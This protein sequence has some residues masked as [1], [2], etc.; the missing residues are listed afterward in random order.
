M[1]SSLTANGQYIFALNGAR[2]F[3]LSVTNVG[4]GSI[5]ILCSPRYSGGLPFSFDPAG[6]VNVN[7][8]GSNG[9]VAVI[10]PPPPVPAATSNP[11]NGVNTQPYCPTVTSPVTANGG[12]AYSTRCDTSGNQFV[13]QA[14]PAPSSAQILV[15]DSAGPAMFGNGN[16]NTTAPTADSYAAFYCPGACGQVDLRISGLT[17]GNLYY[18][19]SVDSTNGSN[20][21]WVS[22]FG[23]QLGLQSP[24]SNTP[25]YFASANGV[26]QLNVT[27]AGWIRVRAAG[28]LS[29]TPT[30]AWSISPLSGYGNG[31]AWTAIKNTPTVTGLADSKGTMGAPDVAGLFADND[32]NGLSMCT[33]SVSQGSMCP[34]VLNSTTSC[35]KGVTEQTGAAVRVSALTLSNTS[36]TAVSVQAYEGTGANCGGSGVAVAIG[37]PILV[38]AGGNVVL[39]MANS[40][41][42]RTVIGD[43]L[44]FGSSASVATININIIGTQFSS[45]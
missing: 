12:T 38:P 10:T 42:F 27:G 20:G 45:R 7:I 17:S 11:G 41:I 36:A 22:G 24:V 35:I 26:Y 39:H 15:T 25:N 19:R 9:P 13:A 34:V 18:E 3:D 8:N 44:C 14:S 2:Y 16:V 43:G 29:G 28:A 31:Y 5:T 33:T 21:G 4:T 6:D 23:I 1:G 37:A 30:V 32:Y 40:E